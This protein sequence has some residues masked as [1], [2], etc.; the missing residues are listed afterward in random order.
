M[1]FN[2]LPK[3]LFDRQWGNR[4]DSED[5]APVNGVLSGDANIETVHSHPTEPV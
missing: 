2:N 3:E 5:G 4:A 1:S